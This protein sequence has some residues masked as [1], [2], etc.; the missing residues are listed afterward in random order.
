MAGWY[1]ANSMLKLRAVGGKVPNE[2]GLYGMHGNVWEWVEDDWH[3]SYKTAPTDG[4]A[5][6]DA[7]QRNKSRVLR[8]GSWQDGARG[9]RVA[10]RCNYSPGNRNQII[11]FR[12][13]RSRGRDDG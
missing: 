8:G 9:C 4:T 1:S 3:N 2:F 6:I 11:G 5:W 13:S 10:F 12:L 7:P